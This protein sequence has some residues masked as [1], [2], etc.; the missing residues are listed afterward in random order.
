M[1]AKVGG[2]LS[3]ADV[4]IGA[5]ALGREARGEMALTA[6]SVDDPVSEA[7]QRAIAAVDGVTGVRVVRIG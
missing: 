2:I 3:D 7:V 5:L 1:L 6:I 4:N